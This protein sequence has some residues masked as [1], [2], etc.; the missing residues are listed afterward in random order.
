MLY[1]AGPR[2]QG[3]NRGG[4]LRKVCA[5]GRRNLCGGGAL[6][7]ASAEARALASCVAALH[8]SRRSAALA[9]ATRESFGREASGFSS[10]GTSAFRAMWPSR[11]RRSAR[12]A[13]RSP[14]RLTRRGFFR[15]IPRPRRVSFP[16][17][18]PYIGPLRKI[19]ARGDG[20]RGNPESSAGP[21]GAPVNRDARRDPASSKAKLRRADTDEASRRPAGGG[22]RATAADRMIEP[23]PGAPEGEKV[24][25]PSPSAN[26]PALGACFARRRPRRADRLRACR[27]RRLCFLG[28]ESRSGGERRPAGRARGAGAAREHARWTPKPNARARRREPRQAGERARGERPERPAPWNSTSG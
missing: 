9:V 19:E 2:P 24:P 14:K 10:F 5:R 25:R 18:V 23:P 6:R 28:L 21:A 8:Y 20:R 15:L 27:R 1:L 26:S 16:W 11:S 7:L 4:A 12:P 17:G 22:P 3:G 13:S